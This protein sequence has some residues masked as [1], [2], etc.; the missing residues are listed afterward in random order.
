MYISQSLFPYPNLTFHTPS[1]STLSPFPSLIL[2]T[3]NPIPHPLFSLPPIT[4]SPYTLLHSPTPHSP[5]AEIVQEVPLL[6]CSPPQS[7]G[8]MESASP[9]TPLSLSQEE[10][11][12]DG[13]SEM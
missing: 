7:A 4:P 8:S 12:Y 13:D 2:S 9:Q 5:M 3:P 1:S 10:N 11:S 6:S